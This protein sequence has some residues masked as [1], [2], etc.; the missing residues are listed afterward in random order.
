MRTALIPAIFISAL[1][2]T[3]HAEE[4]KNSSFGTRNSYCYQRPTDTQN[5]AGKFVEKLCRIALTL[6]AFGAIFL[7]LLVLAPIS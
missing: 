6:T 5:I 7:V 3:R 1:S 4:C 2:R